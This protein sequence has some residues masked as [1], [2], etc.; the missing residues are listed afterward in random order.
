MDTIRLLSSLIEMLN[1][2]MG[3]YMHQVGNLSKALAEELGLE[4]NMVD[5]IEIAGLFHDIGLLGLPEIMLTKD[6]AGLNQTEYD[7]YTQHPV[8]ASLSFETIDRLAEVGKIILSHHE[9]FDG[10]GFPTGLQGSEIHIGA[11]IIAAAAQYCKIVHTWP[12]NAEEIKKRAANN[13]GQDILQHL[14]P[15]DQGP[16]ILLAKTAWASLEIVCNRHYDSKVVEK[17]KKLAASEKATGKNTQWVNIDDLQEGMVLVKELCLKDG[18]HLL[19]KGVALN[20]SSIKSL[21]EL[22]GFKVLDDQIYVMINKD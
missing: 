22:K 11:R 16:E 12:A 21:K 13:F 20:P 1:P 6:E 10:S 2:V 5:Q 8:I 3:N 9:N 7:L 14:G 4:K 18:R 17:L 19:S 15:D